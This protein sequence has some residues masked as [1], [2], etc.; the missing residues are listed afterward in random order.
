MAVVPRVLLLVVFLE[1]VEGLQVLEAQRAEESLLHFTCT[2][3]GR[4]VTGGHDTSWRRCHRW[5]SC[6]GSHI[7]ECNNH[8]M[9]VP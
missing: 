5:G 1:L 8:L 4:W 7:K 6:L 9:I 2:L 3:E